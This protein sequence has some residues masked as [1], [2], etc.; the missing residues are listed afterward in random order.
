VLAAGSGRGNALID[1]VGRCVVGS[2]ESND[3]MSAM[4]LVG[5][6]GLP[7][8]LHYHEHEYEFFFCFDGVVQLWT[9]DESRQMTPGDFGYVPPGTVHSYQL[10]RPGSG[11]VGPIIP[12][13]WDRFFDFCGESFD[14][15]AYPPGPYGFP[16]FEK[17]KAAEEK[18]Q[19]LYKPDATFVKPRFDAADDELPGEQRPYF[20]R[21]GEGER[22]LLGGQLQTA[23]CRSQETQGKLAIT[24]VELPVGAAMPAHSHERTH[25]TIVVLEGTLEFEL[26]GK[27]YSAARGDTVSIPAGCIHSYE[28]KTRYSKLLSMSAPGGLEKLFAL[29][30]EPSEFPIFPADAPTAI[31]VAAA[32]SAAKDLDIEF[33]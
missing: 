8:P 15:P 2:E 5:P 23:I 32:A 29:A 20:L 21:R 7:I 13:G 31:N 26:D 4:T 28:G 11:F 33:A 27:R 30:G 10:H 16:P 25:E 12:A 9:D 24:T 19:M 3:A 22:H 18:F 1:Q 14:G 6:K 17:F